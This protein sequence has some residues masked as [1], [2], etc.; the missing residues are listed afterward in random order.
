MSSQLEID[1]KE[2]KKK[3]INFHFHFRKIKK[4]NH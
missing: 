1:L 4:P 2:E 3:L